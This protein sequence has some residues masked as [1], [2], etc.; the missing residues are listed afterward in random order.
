MNK[1]KVKICGLKR[2]KDLEI[3][4]KLGVDI[5]GFVVEYPIPVPWNIS[6]TNARQLLKMIDNMD[7]VGHSLRSC[8]VTGG[9]PEKVIELA[10]SLKPSMIQLHYNETLQDTIIITDRL[11]KLNIDIIKTIPPSKENRIS[12]FATADIEKIVKLLCD[13]GVYA[14]LVDSRTPANA[15]GSGTLLDIDLCSQIIKLSSKPV[16]IAGGIN[17]GNVSGIISHTGSD[18]IDVMTGIEKEPG[19]KD[20]DMLSNLIKAINK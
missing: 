5:L 4:V 16:I 13:T 3:C 8:L 7:S 11:R 18:Y 19:I 2:E 17:A 10:E 9:P 15:P 20:A 14:L 12:Q 1:V 6:R